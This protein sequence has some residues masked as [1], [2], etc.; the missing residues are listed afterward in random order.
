VLAPIIC[1]YHTH[2][3]PSIAFIQRLHHRRSTILEYT[4]SSRRSQNTPSTAAVRRSD[5]QQ[6]LS[7]KQTFHKQNHKRHARLLSLYQ[8]NTHSSPSHPCPNFLMCNHPLPFAF[9]CSRISNMSLDG[10]RPSRRTPTPR[11]TFSFQ[12]R[13]SKMSNGTATPAL[14]VQRPSND[15]DSLF[16]ITVNGNGT[17]ADE[18]SWKCCQCGKSTPI[19]IRP[20]EHPLGA[21]ACECPHKP[22]GSCKTSGLVKMF[23]PME[24]PAIVP[25]AEVKKNIPF[26]VIC[27]C[28]GLSW[29]AKETGR[30]KKT[31]RKMPSLGLSVAQMH[32]NRRAPLNL[33]LRKSQSTMVLGNK[34]IITPPGQSLG[35]QAEYAKVKFSEIECTC[36]IVIDLSAALCFQVVE[37]QVDGHGKEQKASKE[38]KEVHFE[39]KKVGWSTTPALQ[40][41]GHSRPMIRIR[42]IDHPNPLRSNPVTDEDMPT[43]E[44][45]QEVSGTSW[46]RM[47]NFLGGLLTHRIGA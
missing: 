24:E 43:L 41:Q 33:G 4:I 20:G 23:L 15:S 35:K 17:E 3:I 46:E 26:G 8:V 36:G 45:I 19:G 27:S 44:H 42:G 21:L 37:A 6:L 40:A 25:V 7:P 11:P 14:H 9:R 5:F 1:C 28:C 22:C 47:N 30:Y 39:E 34:R 10:Q 38:R 29:R 16:D 32:Q 18:S 13:Q 2:N 12:Y 31:L